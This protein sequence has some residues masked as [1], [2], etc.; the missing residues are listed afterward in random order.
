[1]YGAG[2]ASARMAQAVQRLLGRRILG[3]AINVKAGSDVRLQRIEVNECG[4]PIPDRKGELG[5]ARI[6]RIASEASADDLIICLI[7][8]GASALMPLPAPPITL[9]E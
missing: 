6:A 2:Q 1:V 3:G 5:A 7:S 8:G 4:H 9:E